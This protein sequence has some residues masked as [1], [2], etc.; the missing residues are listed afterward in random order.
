MEFQL[1][2]EFI[3]LDNLLKVLEMVASGAE[4]RQTILSG[5]VKVNGQIETR[6]RRKLR[7]GDAVEFC[8]Q[9]IKIQGK[10]GQGRA[11]Y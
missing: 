4:A 7:L 2:S 9:L 8:K 11:D 6:I 10:P 5:A 3:E 1:K